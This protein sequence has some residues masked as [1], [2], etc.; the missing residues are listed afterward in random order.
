MRHNSVSVL[1]A[2]DVIL[3]NRKKLKKRCRLL[4]PPCVSGGSVK[5]N[6]AA[7]ITIHKHMDPYQQLRVPVYNELDVR[8]L[9]LLNLINKLEDML[10]HGS[11]YELELKVPWHTVIDK[12]ESEDTILLTGILDAVHVV[13]KKLVVDELKTHNIVTGDGRPVV[14]TRTMMS[15]KYQVLLYSLLLQKFLNSIR[16]GC[17]YLRRAYIGQESAFDTISGHI[18]KIMSPFSTLN[19]LYDRL[20]GLVKQKFKRMR[21]SSAKVTHVSQSLA[22]RA[23]YLNSDE[24]IAYEEYC[25]LRWTYLKQQLAGIDPWKIISNV[26]RS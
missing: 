17:P 14:E 16:S 23:I 22:K 11:V 3:H 25:Q 1:A 13:D 24:A 20:C 18:Q 8:A 19:E 10:E 15:H 12:V 9:K 7:G 2:V 4:S 21:V 26:S 5:D 6:L